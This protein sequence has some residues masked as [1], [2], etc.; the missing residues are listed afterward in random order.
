MRTN[1]V[2]L[3]AAA[4][5]ADLARSIGGEAA[6]R[7]QHLYPVVTADGA[8]TGVV[9]RKDLGK[10]LAAPAPPPPVPGTNGHHPTLSELI[11]PQPVVAYPDEPLRAVVYRMAETGFTRFPVVERDNPRALV[12]MVSLND[13]LRA[14]E[15]NLHEERHREQVLR[16]RVLLPTREPQGTRTG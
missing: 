12:G 14:R 7:G 10:L 6:P 4:T 2:A 16:L 15:R 11:K 5:P 1:V 13:L 3:P 9:T 8:L